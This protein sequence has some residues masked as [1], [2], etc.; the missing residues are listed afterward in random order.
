VQHCN[1]YAELCNTLREI[2][3]IF[4]RVRSFRGGGEYQRWYRFL[5]SVQDC[6]GVEQILESFVWFRAAHGEQEFIGQRAVDVI[7][8]CGKSP[9]VVRAQTVGEFQ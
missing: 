7:E 6:D 1:G 9:Q 8:G 5:L 3:L 4:G 2:S